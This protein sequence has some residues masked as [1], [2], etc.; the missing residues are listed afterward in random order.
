MIADDRFRSGKG[1]S[2]RMQNRRMHIRFRSSCSRYGNEFRKNIR[3]P[4]KKK[5]TDKESHTAISQN[6][7]SLRIPYRL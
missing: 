5:H 2:K 3:I 7:R 6:C 4:H 1:M